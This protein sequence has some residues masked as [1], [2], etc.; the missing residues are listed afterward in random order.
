MYYREV[1]II[2]RFFMK[3]TKFLYTFL[4]SLLWLPS[5]V[6]AQPAGGIPLDNDAFFH[7]DFLTLVTTILEKLIEFGTLL[8]AVM[9]VW[10]GFL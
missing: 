7:G 6:F 2:T 5:G 9:I 4:L 8:L 10:T 3:Y 1:V